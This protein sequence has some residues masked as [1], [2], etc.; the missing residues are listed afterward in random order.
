MTTPDTAALRALFPLEP[1]AVYLNHGTVGVTPWPVLRTRASLLEE[2]ERH[3]ARFMLRELMRLDAPTSANLAAGTPRL[4]AAAAAVAAFLGA[5]PAD[6]SGLV[7][8]D[9]ATA[10]VNAVVDVDP[11]TV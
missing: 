10:G 5:G 9:N 7:F 4:R 1:G 6:G 3:P 11:Q 8:V 2:I